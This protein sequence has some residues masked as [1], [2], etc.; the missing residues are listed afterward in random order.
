MHR[1]STGKVAKAGVAKR[2]WHMKTI[3]GRKRRDS[4]IQEVLKMKIA[5]DLQK[6]REKSLLYSF[7]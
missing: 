6:A 4:A 7:S 2:K 1:F 3:T 5:H